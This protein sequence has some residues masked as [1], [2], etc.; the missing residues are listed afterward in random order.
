MDDEEFLKSWTLWFNNNGPMV[1]TSDVSDGLWQRI[2]TIDLGRGIPVE[3]RV[4]DMAQQIKE[5]ASGILQWMIDGWIEYRELGDL[6]TPDRVK[7]VSNQRREDSDPLGIFLVERYE[8]DAGS[9]VV[10][11]DFMNEF[12]DWAK[13]S[14]ELHIGGRRAVYEELRSKFRLT[15]DQG[16]KG[17]YYIHGLKHLP[18]SFGEMSP[19]S[20]GLE[21]EDRKKNE[22]N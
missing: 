22:N 15:V 20:S 8:F 16:A 2:P 3:E 14:G 1:F 6:C 12:N 11:S 13:A 17:K 5:E 18:M 21:W 19:W 9:K 4:D 7:K 10:A